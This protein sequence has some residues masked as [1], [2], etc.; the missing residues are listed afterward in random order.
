MRKKLVIGGTAL[1][2]V[3][4]VALGVYMSGWGTGLPLFGNRGQGSDGGKTS[5][6]STSGE[7]SDGVVVVVVQGSQYLVNGNPQSLDEILSAAEHATPKA[8]GPR[9]VIRKKG[10]A[11]YLTVDKL[12]KELDSHKIRYVVDDDF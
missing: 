7:S 2:A 5:F 11:R 12:Q 9:V 4:L 1:A 6:I 3:L 8:S 10:D